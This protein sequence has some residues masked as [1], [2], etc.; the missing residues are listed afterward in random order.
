MMATRMKLIKSLFGSTL[1][2][3]AVSPV[4]A[5]EEGSFSLDGYVG[6]TNDYR[7]RGISLSDKDPTVVASVVAYHDSGFFIGTKGAFISDRRGNDG[8]IKGFAGYGFESGAYTYDVSFTV[9]SIHGGEGSQ[10]FPEI[11]GSMARD[12]GLF[13]VRGGLAWAMDGRWHT[14]ENDSLYTFVDVEIPVPTMPEVTIISHFGYDNRFDRSDLLDW[15]VG[16]SAFVDSIELT[17]TYED[18]NVKNPLGSGSVMFG[19]KAYF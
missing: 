18:S 12:F 17:L 1:M 8:Q 14:P 4:M 15:G 11:E 19:I 10:Y 6:I 13:Y 3:L 5:E 16:L 7:D 9:D 2:V